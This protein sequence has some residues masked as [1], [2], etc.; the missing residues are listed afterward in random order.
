MPTVKEL[1]KYIRNNR[2]SGCRPYSKLKKNELSKLAKELGYV[3]PEKKA[4]AK[5]VVKKVPEKKAPAKKAPEKREAVKI[6]TFSRED[7]AK[8]MRGEL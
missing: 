2:P 1:K 3:E 6:Q 4:P 5:A 8:A 7:F